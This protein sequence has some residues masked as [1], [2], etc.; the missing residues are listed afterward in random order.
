[1]TAAIMSDL[2]F[3]EILQKISIIF[4]NVFM[5]AEEWES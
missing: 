4:K 5:E 3:L 2:N 1:M